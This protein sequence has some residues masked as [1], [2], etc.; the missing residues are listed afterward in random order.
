MRDHEIREVAVEASCD[1][2][3]VKNYLRAKKPVQPLSAKRIE[4]AILR[5]G[6]GAAGMPARLDPRQRGAR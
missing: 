4:A 2:R 3:T 5:L 6:L 1:P